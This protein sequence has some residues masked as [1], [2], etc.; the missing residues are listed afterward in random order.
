MWEELVKNMIG[1]FDF[2]GRILLKTYLVRLTF[3]GEVGRNPNDLVGLTL[4]S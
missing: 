3:L 2:Y 4:S 1:L